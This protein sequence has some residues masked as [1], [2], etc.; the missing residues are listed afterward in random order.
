MRTIFVVPSK[1][2]SKREAW[3]TQLAVAADVKGALQKL[4]DQPSRIVLLPK[5]GDGSVMAT[6]MAALRGAGKPSQR[7]AAQT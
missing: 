3:L 4:L 2:T 1:R 7:P 6:L 5:G